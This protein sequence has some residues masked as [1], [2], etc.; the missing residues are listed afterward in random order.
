M[1]VGTGKGRG[2]C[3]PGIRSPTGKLEW[4]LIKL[5]AARHFGEPVQLPP[6]VQLLVLAYMLIDVSV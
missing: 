6:C 4:Q 3:T 5:E 2:W 1:R